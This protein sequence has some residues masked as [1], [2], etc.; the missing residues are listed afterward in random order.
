MLNAEVNNWGVKLSESN[1]KFKFIKGVK[2]ILADTLSRLINLE[3][4]EIKII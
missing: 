3:L 2:N 4:T 1:I